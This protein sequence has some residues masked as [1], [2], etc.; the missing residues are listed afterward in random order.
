[1]PFLHSEHDRERAKKD[2]LEELQRCHQQLQH[3][4]EKS[5]EMR[6]KSALRPSVKRKAPI[7]DPLVEL[8]SSVK[9]EAVKVEKESA[10]A[11][12]FILGEEEKS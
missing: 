10:S 4:Q 7:N 11:L 6:K 5:Q 1:M 2:V 3:Q 9:R 12:S 8:A